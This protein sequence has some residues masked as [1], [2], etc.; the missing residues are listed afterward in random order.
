MNVF[1][2]SRLWFILVKIKVVSRTT[3]YL[4]T[5]YHVVRHK[6]LSNIIVIDAIWLS[7]ALSNKVVN[8]NVT[9]HLMLLFDTF[10]STSD[11]SDVKTPETS[12]IALQSN[13]IARNFSFD[14][15]AD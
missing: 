5:E 6:S 2:H 8:E 7:V 13:R 3:K 14:A 1:S 4:N 10:N 9:H 12:S 15:N 11:V